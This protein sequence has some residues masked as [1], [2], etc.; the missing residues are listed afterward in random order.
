MAGELVQLQDLRRAGGAESGVHEQ[1]RL[2]AT[3]TAAH[4][5]ADAKALLQAVTADLQPMLL[6]IAR[7][8]DLVLADI[9]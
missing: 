2:G 5:L 9:A 7:A 8:S 4:D 1:Q 6:G 3:W